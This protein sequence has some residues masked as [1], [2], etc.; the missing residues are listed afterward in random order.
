MSCKFKGYVHSEWSH[1][2]CCT[3]LEDRSSHRE[4]G[5]GHVESLSILHLSTPDHESSKINVEVYLSKKCYN[6]SIIS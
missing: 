6:F 4:D 3:S 5:E 2:P 1:K